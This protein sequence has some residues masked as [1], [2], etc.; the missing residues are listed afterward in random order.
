MPLAVITGVS[1]GFGRAL[2]RYLAGEGWDL[3]VDSRREDALGEA[4]AEMGAGVIAIPGDVVDPGHRAELAAAVGG[5]SVDLLVNNASVLGPL[6][7]LNGYPV[8]TLEDVF[9][10]N[11]LAP[12]ALVQELLPQM[13]AGG[14]VVNLTSSASVEAYPGFG[15]GG[16]GA[17]KAALDQMNK[18][19]GAEHPEL[20]F[21]AFD[22]GQM[23]TAMWE[24]A[25]GGADMSHL[26]EPEMV[27][28]ALLKLLD[29]APASGR[30]LVSEFTSTVEEGTG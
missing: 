4:A 16:Y 20:R 23:R 8:E 17:S 7:G 11:A 22:P 9:R 30:Y 27:V 10:V 21:Y 15:F 25:S 3:I 29:E 5:R 26:P 12:L 19:L 1:Q 2:A 18:V 13:A 28:P 14:S 6:S 24:D